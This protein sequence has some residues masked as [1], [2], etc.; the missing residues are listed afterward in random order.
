VV[1]GY[2]PLPAIEDLNPDRLV[3]RLASDKKTL[4]GK[5]HFVLPTA[6]GAVKIVSGVEPALIRRAIAGALRLNS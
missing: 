3:M 6:I 1:C 4:A 2:G 5:V